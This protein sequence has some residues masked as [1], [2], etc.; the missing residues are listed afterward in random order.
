MVQHI[1]FNGQE[2]ASVDAMPAS[3]RADFE[4][5]LATLPDENGN[6]VPDVLERFADGPKITCQTSLT[7]NGRAVSG[8][9]QPGLR[10]LVQ[11]LWI[12]TPIALG[13]LFLL[14]R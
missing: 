14:T 2:Y 4:R 10:L 12:L 7:V 11:L 6:G 5:L 3:V 13:A 9:G 1:I 8:S